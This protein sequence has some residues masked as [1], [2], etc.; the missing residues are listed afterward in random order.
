[1]KE[2]RESLLKNNHN[3]HIQKYISEMTADIERLSQ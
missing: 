3:K 2:S 1:M